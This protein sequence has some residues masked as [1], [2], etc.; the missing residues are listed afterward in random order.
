MKLFLLSVLS[1][2]TTFS[3]TA[4]K[5]NDSKSLDALK[6]EA[7]KNIQS[8][9]D[10]YKKIA[11]AIWDYA[12]VGFKENK[13]STL[14]QNTLKDNGF[15]VEAGIAGMPTAFVAT[16]GSGKPVIGILAE[17]DALPGLSQDS[18]ASKMPITGKNSGHGCGHNL[19]GTGSV[20]S[21]I[22]IQKIDGGRKDQRDDKSVWMSSR[23]R[24]RRQSLYGT[25]GFV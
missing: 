6:N 9:Y 17:F 1:L 7:A 10:A 12:E 2:F 23:R 5:S 13:S 25:G 21:G 3:L 24:W 20:A 22:A 8:G 16:F 11:L 4:Q 18:S 14:L 19:F 15:S